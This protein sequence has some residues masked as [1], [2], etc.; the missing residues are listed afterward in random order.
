LFDPSKNIHVGSRVL[1][2]Y[3]NA[4]S[5]NLRRALLKYNGSLGTRSS[6]PDRVMRAYRDF[7]RVTIEG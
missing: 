3:L 7:Q 1:V 5:G 4:H 6:F 2:K